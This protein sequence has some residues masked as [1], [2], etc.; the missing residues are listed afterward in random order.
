M[1]I[2]SSVSRPNVILLEGASS[3]DSFF[4]KFFSQSAW[5]F[6]E[7][8]TLQLKSNAM[9]EFSKLVLFNSFLLPPQA[10]VSSCCRLFAVHTKHIFELYYKF[11]PS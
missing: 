4:G 9:G 1:F 2:L 6:Y 10:H 8:Y 5:M 3:V 11:I 7:I